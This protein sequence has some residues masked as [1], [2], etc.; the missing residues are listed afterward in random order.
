MNQTQKNI[1]HLVKQEPELMLD[2][3]KLY[4]TYCEKVEH[5]EFNRAN[6]LTNCPLPETIRRDRQKVMEIL[7]KNPENYA[8]TDYFWKALKAIKEHKDVLAEKKKEELGYSPS[9]TRQFHQAD[10]E[11]K[12]KMT[13]DDAKD[14]IQ[15][16]KIK[17]FKQ[18]KLI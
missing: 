11:N 5:I 1:F 12:S 8:L 2:D 17:K 6:F 3:R 4:V 10:A 14:K 18:D 9:S 15:Q 16:N 7:Y 13:W